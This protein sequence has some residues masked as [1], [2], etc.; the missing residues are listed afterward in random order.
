M[1]PRKICESERKR[2]IG[3]PATHHDVDGLVPVRVEAADAVRQRRPAL[4]VLLA[5]FHGVDAVVDAVHG[6]DKIAVHLL[7]HAL[8]ALVRHGPL[9]DRSDGLAAK[10]PMGDRVSKQGCRERSRRTCRSDQR[11]SA[12]SCSQAKRS[13][14]TRAGGDQSGSARH[15]TRRRHRRRCCRH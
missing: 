10:V 12:W 6:L 7:V 11:C 15:R 3:R 5:T 2:K 4:V 8:D 14:Q 1:Q 13:R 9:E